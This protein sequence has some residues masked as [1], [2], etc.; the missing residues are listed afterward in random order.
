MR[1]S[2][3]LVILIVLAFSGAGAMHAQISNSI[4][5]SPTPSMM[6]DIFAGGL[7]GTGVVNLTNSQ[8]I[9]DEHGHLSPASPY[10]MAFMSSL[11]DPSSST[12][13]NL[14]TEL[15]VTALGGSPIRVTY[16][17]RTPEDQFVVKDLDWDKTGTKVAFLVSGNRIPVPQIWIVSFGPGQTSVQGPGRF[18]PAP[19]FLPAGRL[20]QLRK[21]EGSPYGRVMPPLVSLP[22]PK[23]K[24]LIP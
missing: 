3:S 23:E 24:S 11:F 19:R 1:I 5:Y 9:W 4:S 17:N 21:F 16:F 13:S 8:G 15:Y 10:V 22:D 18:Q 6:E 12:D 20:F 7:N 2:I 14:R